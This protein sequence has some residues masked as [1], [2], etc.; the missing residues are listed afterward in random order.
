[1]Y[2][3][4]AIGI[5]EHANRIPG[6]YPFQGG[7][8]RASSTCG[9][10]KGIHTDSSP[11]SRRHLTRPTSGML[12]IHNFHASYTSIRGAFPGT[13]SKLWAFMAPSVASHLVGA[14]QDPLPED[15]GPIMGCKLVTSE[16]W[17]AVCRRFDS[18]TLGTMIIFNTS[19]RQARWNIHPPSVRTGL[20]GLHDPIHPVD[21]YLAILG[22]VISNTKHS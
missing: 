8:V 19:C 13:G 12:S 18:D 1:M 21:L 5:A 2:K 17:N 14:P 22:I 15:D 6:L 7:E 16:A 3:A 11:R 9:G 10:F 20:H 4:P